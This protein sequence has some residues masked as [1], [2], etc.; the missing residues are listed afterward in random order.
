MKNSIL[1]LTFLVIFSNTFAQDLQDWGKYETIKTE[2][3]QRIEKYRRILDDQIAQGAPI[4]GIGFQSRIKSGLITPD[5]IYK[6][7]RDFEK[8][9]L[10]YQ[11]TEFEVRDNDRTYVYT[12]EERK[13]ITKY[14]MVMYLNHP[15][16]EG[17][18]HWT[19]ADKKPNEVLDYP[20]FNYDGAPKATGKKWIE[21]MEGFFNTDVTLTTD[22][23]GK[24][25][26]KGYY[27]DY[28]VKI[29]RE[30]EKFSAFLELSSTKN[31]SSVLS[32][33]LNKGH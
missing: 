15:N 33:T 27:G 12:D 28:E 14:M 3:A 7:L 17:F 1:L 9:N 18:W 30:G 11:A 6:R 5:T 20:L 26:F 23:N 19:F 31:T 22:E 13:L 16:V 25:N 4:D 24:M 10:P 32:V 2:A 29:D 8:Y 21:L